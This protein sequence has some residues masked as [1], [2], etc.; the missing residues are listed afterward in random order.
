MLKMKFMPFFYISAEKKHTFKHQFG[1]YKYNNVPLQ[2]TPVAI[3]T[4]GRPLAYPCSHHVTKVILSLLLYPAQHSDCSLPTL[5]SI[6]ASLVALGLILQPSQHSD[7]HQHIPV[8]L[9]DNLVGLSLPLLRSQPI[10]WS[11]H[12]QVAITPLCWSSAYPFWNHSQTYGPKPTTVSFTASLGILSLSLL[13]SQPTWRFS[14]YP[15]SH[16]SSLMVVSLSL[17][18]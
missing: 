11:Q 8:A 4:L 10:W 1:I 13:R 6:T 3:I 18:Q 12:K 16:H 2:P 17:L 14:A 15:C 5:V 9:T 7:G